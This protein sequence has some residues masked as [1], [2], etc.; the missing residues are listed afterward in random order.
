M[1][2]T[3]LNAIALFGYLT[4]AMVIE[5]QEQHGHRHDKCFLDLDTGDCDKQELRWFYSN[6][7]GL[8]QTF[9]Y[10]GCGGNANNFNSSMYCLHACNGTTGNLHSYTIDTSTAEIKGKEQEQP[11][12]ARSRR[13][14]K[15]VNSP[16]STQGLSDKKDNLATSEQQPSSTKSPS[17]TLEKDVAVL[18]EKLSMLGR[19]VDALQRTYMSTRSK[20]HHPI[21][22]LVHGFSHLPQSGDK[23][24][25]SRLQDFKSGKDITK[26]PRPHIPL[27]G[28]VLP[29]AKPVQPKKRTLTKIATKERQFS[30]NA[31]PTKLVNDVIEDDDDEIQIVSNK[32]DSI[33]K[34]PKYS[35]SCKNISP[36]DR[37]VLNELAAQSELGAFEVETQAEG[38]ALSSAEA[39]AEKMLDRKLAI[40]GDEEVNKNN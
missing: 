35:F 33:I 37:A 11:S 25:S 5:G 7:T 26:E 34:D 9:L 17:M 4:M 14:S 32:I 23:K 28:H 24:D 40:P 16:V 10:S 39:Q 20:S 1:L 31:I 3:K 19:Y 8:C 22:Q 13:D 21:G 27:S 38:A 36:E 12:K 15:R 30:S 18:K 6:A 2:C 29:K